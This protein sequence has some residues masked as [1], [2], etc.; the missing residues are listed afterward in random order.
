MFSLVWILGIVLFYYVTLVESRNQLPWKLDFAK[1]HISA[2]ALIDGGNIYR[3]VPADYF[4]PLGAD[5][6]DAPAMLHPNL[7]M[8]FVVVLL[9]PFGLLDLDTGMRVW[10][11]LS[12]SFLMAA[13]CL[14]GREIGSLPGLHTL[15][16]WVVVGILTI[17]LLVYYPNWI[18]AALGQLGQLLLLVVSAAWISARRGRDRVA[19]LL[20]GLAL[21][22]KPFTGIFLLLLPWLGR[23]RITAWCI[24][25]AVTFAGIAAMITGP[26]SYLHYLAGLREVD[27]HAN[28]WNA[29]LMA[30]LTVFTGGSGPGALDIPSL[31]PPIWI[32]VSGALYAILVVALR[33]IA[34][35]RTRLDIAVAGAVPLMLLIS[36]LGWLYYLS[37]IWITAIALMLATADLSHRAWWRGGT[38]LILIVCGLPFPFVMANK[39][40]RSYETMLTTSADTMALLIA[41]LFVVAAARALHRGEY[42][43]GY[44][45][46]DGNGTVSGPRCHPAAGGRPN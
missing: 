27:W 40:G 11:W 35:D 32:A 23:W 26:E 39:A 38:V 21:T 28:G 46:I 20:F 24:A 9:S 30:P 19:G 7:N 31:R 18:N 12:I 17:F 36:P 16:P 37:L 33:K 2:T 29:S 5:A 34:C 43:P 44:V 14:L 8:P 25:S 4:G 6:E 1:F 22:L 41:F 13:A 10:T 15:P 45:S 42:K 3:R